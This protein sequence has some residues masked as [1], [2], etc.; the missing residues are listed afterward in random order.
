MAEHCN[1]TYDEG[2]V[3]KHLTSVIFVVTTLKFSH[4]IKK[5]IL[6]QSYYLL[7]ALQFKRVNIV[8]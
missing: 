7:E 3:Y 2:L 6:L 5:P 1:F 8:L 4:L